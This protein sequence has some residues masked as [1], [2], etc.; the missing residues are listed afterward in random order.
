VITTVITAL[1]VL[2]LVMA[3]QTGLWPLAV[4]LGFCLIY[5]I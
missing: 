3:V 2:L 1:V 4:F 5:G